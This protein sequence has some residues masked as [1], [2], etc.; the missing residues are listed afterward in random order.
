MLLLTQNIKDFFVIKKKAGVVF[1]NLTAAYNTVW[2]CDLTCK[3]LRLLPD[4]HMV[5]MIMELIRQK[6]F[7]LHFI[8][9]TNKDLHSRHV[10]QTRPNSKSVNI[11]PRP[12]LAK[13]CIIRHL[14]FTIVTVHKI[15]QYAGKFSIKLANFLGGKIQNIT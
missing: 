3:L 11:S 6:T 1:I 5:R 13:F 12:A 9:R 8:Q 7:I 15:F 4:K 10:V 2:H 14:F